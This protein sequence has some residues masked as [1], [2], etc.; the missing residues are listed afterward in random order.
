MVAN[1]STPEPFRLGVTFHSFTNEYCSFQWSFE[2]MMRHAAALGGGVE[3]VGPAHHRGFPQVPAEFERTFKSSVERNGLTP[4]CYG[5]YAD[6]FMLPGR[7]LSPDEL[8]AYTIPQLVGAARLGFPIVRLQYFVAPVVERLLPHAEKLGLRMGYELHTPLTI[9]SVQTQDLLAQVKRLSSPRL[10][11]IPDAGIFA[12]SIPKFRIEGA[13]KR[14]VPE[15][16]LDRAVKLWQAKTPL[17]EAQDVLR[18]HGADDRTFSTLEVF[19]GSFGHSEPAA[20]RQIMPYVIHVHGKFFSMAE[21]DE[22][23][24]RYEELVKALLDGGYQGWMSSE[25]EGPDTDSF[26]IVKAHQGMVRRYVAQYGRSL[27]G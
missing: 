7:D 4:T 8:V 20:M 6:P 18:S 22:P 24:V 10:G 21:G 3:I 27:K 14:G 16:L 25:Y 13:R 5:S 9:E 15:P 17:R 1:M 19:W 23:D 11:L 26:E 2:D 12:R